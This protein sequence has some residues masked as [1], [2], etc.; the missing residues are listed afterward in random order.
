MIPHEL[1]SL[2][3]G[4]GGGGSLVI[5]ILDFNFIHEKTKFYIPFHRRINIYIRLLLTIKMYD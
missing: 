4:G 1:W 5:D 2:G 3:G